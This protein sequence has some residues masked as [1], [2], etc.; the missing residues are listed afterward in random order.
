MPLGRM[1]CAIADLC[2]CKAAW[3]SLC[4]LYACLRDTGVDGS[5]LFFGVVWALL[6]TA[7][8]VSTVLVHVIL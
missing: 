7:F 6:F 8:L 5:S 3:G 4:M 2:I 1:V